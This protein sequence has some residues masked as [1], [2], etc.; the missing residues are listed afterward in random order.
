M[1]F[2]DLFNHRLARRGVGKKL[3]YRLAQAAVILALVG[4]GQWAAPQM[5]PTPQA[6]ERATESKEPALPPTSTPRAIIVEKPVEIET[7]TPTPQVEPV[8]T[9]TVPPAAPGPVEQSAL[10][11]GC[12]SWERQE[13]LD[14]AGMLAYADSLLHFT[15]PLPARQMERAWNG[16]TRSWIGSGALA[17]D[18]ADIQN[19]YL[20]Q[21]ALNALQV[22]GF[23]TWLRDGRNDGGLQILAIPLEGEI[24]PEWAPYIISYWQGRDTL[25]EGDETV[26]PALKLPPCAWAVQQGYTQAAGQE[27]WPPE[28]T[29]IPN[30]AQAADS[31]QAANAWEALKIAERIN[32]LGAGSVEDAS[33]MCGPLSWSILADAQSWPLG[34]GGW[35]TGPKSFWLSDPVRNGRPWSLFARDDYRVYHF[36]E[37]LGKFDFQQW[38]LYPGDFLYTYSRDGFDHMLVVTEVDADGNVYTVTNLIKKYPSRK[39]T[40]ERAVL[41]H[42]RDLSV[43]LARNDWAIDGQNGRTG[44]DGF[45][46]FRWAWMEKNI[47]QAPALYITRP[48]DTFELLAERWRTPA[49]MIAEFNLRQVGDGLVVGETLLIPAIPLPGPVTQ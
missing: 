18:M 34:Y 46:V 32:W 20:A 48:G 38:P 8:E 45:D 31:Y 29:Q 4:C 13:P 5:P 19:L 23:V 3:L 14:L 39:I 43:G 16:Y 12:L 36:A 37:P 44:N 30:Y 25:P 35:A 33:N 49:Q 41:Y 26:I 47:Q 42:P 11:A 21:E 10:P 9:A 17:L 1:T 40:I 22:A 27:W 15:R 2:N 24:M 7:P 6:T 28:R